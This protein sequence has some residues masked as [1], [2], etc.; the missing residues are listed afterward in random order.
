MTP[1]NY[2][3]NISSLALIKDKRINSDTIYDNTLGLENSLTTLRFRKMILHNGSE[4][5]VKL[6]FG[7]F[8]F[9]SAIHN[10]ATTVSGIMLGSRGNLTFE[11]YFN[12]YELIWRSYL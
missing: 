2:I 11:V 4:D 7:F 1:C 6:T 8:K 10:L 12:E 9:N 5:A 3:Y